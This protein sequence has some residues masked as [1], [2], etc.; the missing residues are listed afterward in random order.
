MHREGFVD[1]D[2]LV[3]AGGRPTRDRRRVCAVARRDVDLNRRVAAAVGECR[4]VVGRAGC[5][6][7]GNR[8]LYKADAEGRDMWRGGIFI[9]L[10]I[11][12]QEGG[13]PIGRGAIVAIR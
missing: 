1:V 8:V 7:Y 2:L 5:L 11:G 13:L 4:W 3:R 12:E 9:P 10:G 6:L